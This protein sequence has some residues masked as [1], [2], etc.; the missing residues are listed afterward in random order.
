MKRCVSAIRRTV[1]VLCLLIV[2]L[3]ARV[4]AVSAGA[5]VALLVTAE[6]ARVPTGGEV[7]FTVSVRALSATRL[8][9]MSFHVRRSDSLIVLGAETPA[10]EHFILTSYNPESGFFSAAAAVSDGL[11]EGETWDLLVLTCRV[12]PG[13]E[14]D[15]LLSVSDSP[16]GTPDPKWCVFGLDENGNE[17][18]LACDLSRASCSVSLVLPEEPEEE[19]KAETADDDETDS[20]E[21]NA[22]SDSAPSVPAEPETAAPEDV[23]PSVPDGSIREEERP[24]EDIRASS[25]DNVGE[26]RQQETDA[27]GSRSETEEIVP[28][29]ERRTGSG[30]RPDCLRSRKAV[31][32]VSGA[33]V[34][35]LAASGAALRNRRKH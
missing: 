35:L 9:G 15:L 8:E 34:S 31:L 23:T 5:G 32:I 3:S 24:P 7:V 30:R 26:A 13:A 28:Q 10:D 21:K 29:E 25:Q 33:A 19:G 12:D 18:D 2:F 17:T 22:G 20:D 16:D 11:P 1:F 14:E 6:P 4:T 27:E